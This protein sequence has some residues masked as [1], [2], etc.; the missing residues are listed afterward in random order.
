MHR[1]RLPARQFCFWSIKNS[2]YKLYPGVGRQQALERFDTPRKNTFPFT[3]ELGDRLNE[4]LNVYEPDF[5]EMCTE[6]FKCQV[7]F[8]GWNV[9]VPFPTMMF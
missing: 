9:P 4:V 1:Y 7:L 3:K 6:L 8:H 5:N 2:N